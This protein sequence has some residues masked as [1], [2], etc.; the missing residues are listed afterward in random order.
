MTDD[1]E[2]RLR[3]RLLALS[4]AV[5]VE[6][7]RGSSTVVPIR[8]GPARLGRRATTL[9]SIATVLVAIA[10]LV[11]IGSR[12]A[13]SGA[14]QSGLLAPTPS[15]VLQASP[16]ASARSADLVVS[17]GFAQASDCTRAL[18]ATL[19]AV[20]NV[21]FPPAHL[22]F[23]QPSLCS[24]PMFLDGPIAGLCVADPPS[25]APERLGHAV[26]TFDGVSRWAYLN[27]FG[28]PSGVVA[29]LIAVRT[30]P[31][32]WDHPVGSSPA[33]TETIGPSP[34]PTSSPSP[35]ASIASTCYRDPTRT[36][37]DPYPIRT[38]TIVNDGENCGDPFL[39]AGTGCPVLR[40]TIAASVTFSGRM[41][42]PS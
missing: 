4:E 31:A 22:T 14:A 2:T 3:T 27:I 40:Y 35:G 19:A 13:G 32:Y 1:L 39:S 9:G 38:I 18:P 30:Q 29:S 16:S 17:C 28:G 12:L 8:I 6:P 36:P 24:Q 23:A 41:P 34:A 25:G 33:P 7:I 20:R 11:A 42:W 21:G 15:P 5:P 37:R 10:L 26:V